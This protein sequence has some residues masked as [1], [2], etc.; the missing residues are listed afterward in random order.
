[1]KDYPHHRAVG[2]RTDTIEELKPL[3]ETSANEQ[4]THEIVEK[5]GEQFVKFTHEKTVR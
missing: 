3:A 1:M 2:T 5:D 4:K